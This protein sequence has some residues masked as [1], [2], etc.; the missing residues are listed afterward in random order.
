MGSWQSGVLYQAGG[1]YGMHA[2]GTVKRAAGDTML[3]FSMQMST[4]DILGS[5]DSISSVPG[6]Q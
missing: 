4:L 3:K 2:H 6:I 5:V 1:A